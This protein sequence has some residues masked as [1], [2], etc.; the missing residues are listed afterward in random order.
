VNGDRANQ[1]YHS[2]ALGNL[3]ANVSATRL[4]ALVDK[5]FKGGDLP[6]IVDPSLSTLRYERAAGSLFVN[7]AA[8]P[9]SIK[10][11]WGLL[12]PRHIG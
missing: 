10:V 12:L 11:L 4:N 7:G 1:W 5:W 2:A 6:Q 3:T 9:T 8:T